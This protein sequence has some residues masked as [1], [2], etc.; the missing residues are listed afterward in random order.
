MQMYYEIRGQG[1]PLVLLHGY[2]GSGADWELIFKEPPRGYRLV[3]PDLR[4]HGQSTNPS[5]VFTFRQS[6]LDVF[7]LLDR[8]D[9]QRFKAIGVS[10][11]AEILLR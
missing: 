8:L 10:G 11:G 3:I 9:I 5:M 7:A 1:E 2:T 6:A 4:G